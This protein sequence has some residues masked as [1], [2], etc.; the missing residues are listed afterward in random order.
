MK[1]C[2]I[3][4][5]SSH[6]LPEKHLDIL[7][8]NEWYQILNGLFV[9]IFTATHEFYQKKN[10]Q[11]SLFPITTGAISSPMGLGSDSLPI[12]VKINGQKVF[13]ADSMQFCL[14]IG[15][16]L[17]EKGAYYIMPT[18]RG[19]KTDARHLNEFIHSEVE[20]KG[21][22]DDIMNLAE[23]Y[24]KYLI[25]YILKHNTEQISKI[26][27]NVD[28]LKN[29]LKHKFYRIDYTLAVSELVKIKGAT[30]QIGNEFIDITPKGEKIILDKY[31]D[32]TWLVNLPW[33]L[34]PF[35]QAKNPNQKGSAFAADLL[36]GIGEILGCGQRVL[37]VE[38]LD[39]SLAEHNV[40]PLPY[41]WY[42]R[43]RE[44]NCV[45][46]SGFGLGIERFILWIL[47]HNDIRDC[48]ILLRD[49]KKIIGP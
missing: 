46:T 10:I 38:D 32:F 11:P 4:A 15:A 23:E 35:Y 2:Y 8:Q 1:Q 40:D 47:R 43:M 41:M 18:F 39:T 28:H 45:Q 20:I 7:L 27:G 37:T 33:K 44:I 42:R 25:R 14:E 48:T 3:K 17:N 26:T 6:L 34:V 9:S 5:P 24:I 31:G 22:R 30:K 12:S 49:H 29:A 13:L 36:A 21:T 19:E 16:R